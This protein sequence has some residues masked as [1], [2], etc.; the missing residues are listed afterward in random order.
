MHCI[1]QML[2][3]TYVTRI[4]TMPVLIP[5][6]ST[7]GKTAIEATDDIIHNHLPRLKDL[8]RNGNLHIDNIDVFCEKGVFDLD[9]TRRI[10]EGGKKMGLQINFHGDELHPMK[11][12][13]V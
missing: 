9:T 4:K 7:R 11:A 13:E 8:G 6:S 2:K 12:A 1:S 10:L 5:F 3:N